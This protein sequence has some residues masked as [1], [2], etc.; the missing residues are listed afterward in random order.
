MARLHTAAL[1]CFCVIGYAAAM[2]GGGPAL[3]RPTTYAQLD[4]VKGQW[5]ITI[6]ATKGADKD[7]F[8]PQACDS[9][10]LDAPCNQP[11]LNADAHDKLKITAKVAKAPLKA[12]DGLKPE[13]IVI[14]MCFS[15]PFVA[16]RP[17]RKPN[18]IIDRDRSCPQ[19]VA[20]LPVA[21]NNTYTVTW[22]IPK[23]APK[24][25]WYVKVFA[26]CKNG[27]DTVYCQF[28]STADKAY[29]ATSI[30]ESTPTAMKA[31]VAVCSAIAPVFLALFFIKERVLKK[32]A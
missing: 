32:T 3:D 19:T 9:P 30:I 2:G 23:A 16:D 17:W 1:L 15:K 14:K 12:A 4:G 10:V 26:D 7:V 22:P 20:T 5:D 28:D 13:H 31:A 21:A 25:T 6:E 24:A 18:D 8:V 29:V 11:L 27:T